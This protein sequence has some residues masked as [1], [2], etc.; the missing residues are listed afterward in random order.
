MRVSSPLAGSYWKVNSNPVGVV[1]E[2]T[3]PIRA[4]AGTM[5]G[6]AN[7]PQGS[8]VKSG[9]FRVMNSLDQDALRSWPSESR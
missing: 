9:R 1:S 3:A 8:E 2:V 4:D 6:K 7:G 5:T